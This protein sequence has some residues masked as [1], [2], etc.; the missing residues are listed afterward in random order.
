MVFVPR[1]DN[2]ITSV[3]VTHI[4]FPS[5]LLPQSHQMVPATPAVNFLLK[6]ERRKKGQALALSSFH[7]EKYKLS[8]SPGKYLLYLI[9]Q[10]F[11]TWSPL[12]A[13]G[14]E[15]SNIL[16]GP[17]NTATANRIQDQLSRKKGQ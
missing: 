13:W 11:M 7:Q 4:S 15:S 8:Q 1:L 14:S 16:S 17:S 6:V 9:V 12:P 5:V 10:K 3:Y 2:V